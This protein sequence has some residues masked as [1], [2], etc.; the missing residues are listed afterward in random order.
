MKKVIDG[1]MRNE[2]MVY[3]SQS[4]YDKT[5]K[6]FKGVWDVE[7]WDLPNWESKREKYMGKRT[8]MPPFSLFDSTCLLV[9]GDG[10]EILSDEEWKK[11]KDE[12]YGFLDKWD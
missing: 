5:P 11:K 1:F 3:V 10:M 7:R 4:A 12:L 2:S 8:I 9:E 6:D